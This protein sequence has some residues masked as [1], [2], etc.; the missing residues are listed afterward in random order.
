MKNI[1]LFSTGFVLQNVY[2]FS[3]WLTP[4][5]EFITGHS[6]PHVFRVKK[7]LDGKVEMAW[8]GW[9][10]DKVLKHNYNY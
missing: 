1:N 9:S 3:S 8:K 10:T 4:S 6:K 5:L 2:D 7:G